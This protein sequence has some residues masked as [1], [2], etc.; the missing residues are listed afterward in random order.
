MAAIAT[1]S[2]APQSAWP[3]SGFWRR[4]AASVIDHLILIVPA[5]ILGM[6]SF[7]LGGIALLIAYGTY[8]ESSEQ[9]ATWGKQACGLTVESLAGERLSVGTALFRQVIKLLGHVLSVISWLIVFVPAAFTARKQGLHDMAVSSVVRR[10]PGKG[11]PSWLVGVIAG[12]VPAIFVVGILAAIAIPA[13]ADYVMRAKVAEG[14]MRSAPLQVAV[15]EAYAR[16]GQLPVDESQLEKGSFPAAGSALSYRNGRIEIS[17]N[18]GGRQA[19]LT[20]TPK[21]DGNRIRWTCGGEDIRPGQ[22]PADC[23]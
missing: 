3:Y 18:T 9:R 21:V 8:F 6:F 22:L 12:I 15:Q 11:I 23:R 7:G 20:L 4:V 13:Y 1:E 16:T 14:R 19:L 2:Q 5:G 17:L 10:E